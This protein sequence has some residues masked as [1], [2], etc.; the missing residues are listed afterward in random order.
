MFMGGT[1]FASNIFVGGNWIIGDSSVANRIT[2]PGTC[3]LSQTLQI[4]NAVEQLG[5][6]IVATDSTIDLAGSASRLNFA[7][8]SG[9]TWAAGTI[10]TITNWNGNPA[11]GGA[12]QLKFGTSQ[13]GLTSAQLSQIRFSS[14]S[15]LYSAKILNHR[16]SGARTR[17]SAPASPFRIRAI[18]SS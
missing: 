18:T 10:L 16:R 13:S 3:S 17:R 1:L 12:E 6:L 14:S 5:R 11:G 8:S 15:N 2:N 4:S 7:N 9:E